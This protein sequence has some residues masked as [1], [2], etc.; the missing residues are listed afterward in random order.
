M[1]HPAEFF[2]RFL[3]I[4]SPEASSDAFILKQLDDWGFLSPQ[5]TYLGFLRQTIE[6]P[7]TFMP[8]DRTHRASM[9]FLRDQGVYEL[10]FPTAGVEEAW[11]ILSDPAKRLSIEQV[12]MSRM[13]TKM[14]ATK[15]NKKQ[16][17]KLTSEGIE[18]F[19][20]YFWNVK[21]LTFDEWGRYLYGRSGMYERYID[22][23]LA[24]PQLAMHHLRLDQVLESKNMIQ[25]AQEIA[26]F[27]LEEAAAKPGINDQKIKSIGVFTK[28][29]VECHEALSTSDMALKDVLKQFERFR[30]EYPETKPPDIKA[31][32]PSGNFTNS[33]I[34]K[35]G[36]V[37]EKVEKDDDD[38]DKS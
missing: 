33:G 27:A 20:K 7:N 10:F 34:V 30:M 8:E 5:D 25:R 32:A 26:Y 17:W 12:L 21:L 22:L 4:K 6:I 28:A 36:G 29:I 9:K 37:G 18:A 38:E 11:D 31:L 19:G 2:I 24:P 35:P 16:N 13:D 15:L 14:A 3:I 1:R 23:L